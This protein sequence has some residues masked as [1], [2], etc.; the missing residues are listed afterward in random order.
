M[1]G[2][3]WNGKTYDSLSK[4]AFAITGTQWNGPRFFGLRDKGC[5]GGQAMTT[6]ANKTCAAPSIPGSRPMPASTRTST[7]WM[8][9]MRR[10]GLYPQP[11]PCRLDAG[12]YA[13]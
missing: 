1:T 12:P 3:A 11:G 4:I 6:A 13:L 5:C 2:F 7:H 8:P 9:S 10:A